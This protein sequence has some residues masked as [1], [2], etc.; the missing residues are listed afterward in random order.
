MLQSTDQERLSNKEGSKWNT[1]VSSG[2]GNRKE[3]EDRLNMDGNGN[4]RN[5]IGVGTK[6]ENLEMT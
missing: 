1:W 2:R 3:F 6:A 5:N 4:G